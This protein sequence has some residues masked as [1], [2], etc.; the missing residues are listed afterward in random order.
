M[1][2]LKLGTV[3]LV[4]VGEGVPS[5]LGLGYGGLDDSSQDRKGGRVVPQVGGAA[6]RTGGS[7]LQVFAEEDFHHR[8]R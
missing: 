4:G 2:E 1:R 8:D 3:F 7:V 5:Q 6:G